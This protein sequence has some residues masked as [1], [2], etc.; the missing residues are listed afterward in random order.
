MNTAD[1]VLR[2]R[3]G[4]RK[5]VRR[6][7]YR[8]RT[9]TTTRFCGLG[10]AVLAFFVQGQAAYAGT[11]TVAT[12]ADDFTVNGNCSLREAIQA[13]NTD[14]AVD[15][16][17]GGSG[18]DTIV[19]PAGSFTLSIP[20]AGED[21]NATGDLDIDSD[22]TIE[23]S[24]AAVSV[25]DGGGL[26]RVFNVVRGTSAIVG[27]T[28][29]N[30]NSPGIPF[31]PLG[32][33]GGIANG[34][35]L[36]L[37]NSNVIS[38]S[39]IGGFGVGGGIANVG[40]LGITAS[41]I[42]GN[43]A[44]DSHG[45]GI[46]NTGMLTV[47]GSSVNGNAANSGAGGGIFN[48]VG[49]TTKLTNVQ[50]SN[51]TGSDGGGIFEFGGTL[52]LNSSTVSGNTADARG[53]MFNGRGGGIWTR[54]TTSLTNS[55][56]SGNK[57]IG[58]FSG[59]SGGT[60]GGIFSAGSLSL[61][62]S[63]ISGNSAT[64]GPGGG[65]FILFGTTS[66]KRTI[67]AKNTTSDCSGSTTSEGHNLDSD[68]TCS[69]TALGDLRGV[70]PLLGPLA[71]NG[72]P[73]QTHALLPGS[74]AIDVGGSDCPPP[75]TDQRG[76][77]RP[78]GLGCDTGAFE[79]EADTTPPAITV[80]GPITTDATS[81]N[82]TVV[83]YAVSASDPDDA[84]ASLACVPAS[85]STFPI[86]TTTVVCTATDTHGNSASSS[87]TVHVKGAGEQLADLLTAITGVGPGRS[88]ADKVAQAQTQLTANDIPAVCSTLTTFI[89][90]VKAQS[91]KT[92]PTSKA[93]M[94]IESAGRIKSVLGC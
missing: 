31:S 86:G 41:T 80:P 23:G 67:V 48:D 88:L 71:D 24:G 20:G 76:V 40:T 21:A 78:Q 30:G 35:S 59:F 26:D 89:S 74:P 65:I 92:I 45:G 55:T 42:N 62:S 82:G 22:V 1:H 91:S 50:I 93:A 10:A 53:G 73:T 6:T 28:I 27:V 54:G 79:L 44:M 4:V 17:P 87:F 33:G 34:G 13:A 8:C 83:T 9:R 49:G 64:D 2:S 38:N 68:N 57:A 15:A 63:T 46:F 61:N 72:G 3:K 37:S 18:A 47:T 84:V 94:L 81:Q 69:L 5:K 19:V 14:T 77:S 25:I 51:N 7:S 12:N 29:Q 39:A 85:G 36:T 90:E 32:G 58:V 52:S 56:V 11:I 70:D 43:T 75:A 66:L 60:G 16:C